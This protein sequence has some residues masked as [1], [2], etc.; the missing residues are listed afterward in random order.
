[1]T[2]EARWEFE[3]AHSVIGHCVKPRAHNNELWVERLCNLLFR[4][5]KHCIICFWLYLDLKKSNQEAKEV[6]GVGHVHVIVAKVDIVTLASSLSKSAPPKQIFRFST[7]FNNLF[8]DAA[9]SI[10]R[11][12]DS[13]FLILL[14]CQ[15]FTVKS[16]LKILVCANWD[17]C[18][19]QWW[20]H[21]PTPKTTEWRF[22]LTIDT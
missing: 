12:V 14:R 19:S 13:P 9:L 2:K 20:Q 5:T 3:V 15:D 10:N 11:N 6:V 4:S 21:T 18:V 1:M 17:N 7:F 8:K 22:M 16:F